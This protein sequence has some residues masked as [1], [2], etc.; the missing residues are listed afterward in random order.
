MRDFYLQAHIFSLLVNN[1][2]RFFVHRQTACTYTLIPKC[3]PQRHQARM[4]QN[5]N[6]KSHR[7]SNGDLESI[8]KNERNNRDTEQ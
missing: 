2:L 3:N 5:I 6:G 1:A 4:H 7:N 8:I